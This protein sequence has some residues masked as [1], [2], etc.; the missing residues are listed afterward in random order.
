[1]FRLNSNHKLVK[2][3]MSVSDQKQ[4]SKVEEIYEEYSNDLFQNSPLKDDA[5]LS[6]EP[7]SVEDE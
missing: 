7:I 2:D 4:P 1:M 5:F 6:K 3:S